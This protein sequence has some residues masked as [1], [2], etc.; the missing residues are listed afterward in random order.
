MFQ[1]LCTGEIELALLHLAVVTATSNACISCSTQLIA[2]KT[3]CRTD[4]CSLPPCYLRWGRCPCAL[5]SIRVQFGWSEEGW[6]T[7]GGGVEYVN[8]HLRCI[9][10]CPCRYMRRYIRLRGAAILSYH[11]RP[12]DSDGIA[13][14]DSG[15]PVHRRTNGRLETSDIFRRLCCMN[16]AGTITHLK[17]T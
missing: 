17:Y 7:L 2:M 6:D 16:P 1:T 4:R 11:A 5:E 12:P 8:A 3:V 9:W 10:R 13:I 14:L 15:S